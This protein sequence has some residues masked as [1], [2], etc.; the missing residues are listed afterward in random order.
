MKRE[1]GKKNRKTED[2][3]K[4]QTWKKDENSQN[5]ADR[6][7]KYRNGKGW[8]RK[9]GAKGSRQSEYARSVALNWR[10]ITSSF[11]INT[12]Y[13]ITFYTQHNATRSIVSDSETRCLDMNPNNRYVHFSSRMTN[14][15]L[16]FDGEPRRFY[17][18]VIH[19]LGRIYYTWLKVLIVKSNVSRYRAFR[20]IDFISSKN[21][22]FHI[23]LFSFAHCF[24]LTFH[25]WKSFVSSKS[26]YLMF[27]WLLQ[28][29][30]SKVLFHCACFSFEYLRFK[31]MYVTFILF[32]ILI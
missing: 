17:A 5:M 11:T 18:T 32:I 29:L 20:Y 1:K 31:F 24:H 19:S 23:E 2:C 6:E 28:R 14:D 10:P 13:Y 26:I 30:S 7:R 9:D 25:D 16:F 3:L 4:N 22:G 21:R 12:S 27:H 8:R 15:R